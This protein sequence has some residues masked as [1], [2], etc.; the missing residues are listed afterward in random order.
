M[1]LNRL[2]T[3]G[4]ASFLLLYSHHHEQL[5]KY[6]C[7]NIL[8]TIKTSDT[9]LIKIY[10]SLYLKG[11]CVRGSWRPNRTA[12]Y[13]PPLLW[14]SPFFFPFS[15]AAQLKARGPS[16]LLG[17]VFSAASF[18]HLFWSPNW[19]NFLCTELYN[20][21]TSTQYLP[22]TSHRN[23]H[24]YRLWNGMF[25]RHR[26]EIT[27]MQ[28]TGHSLPV[29]QFVTVPWDSKPVPYCQPSPPTPMEYALPPSLEWHVWPGR[30]SV[31][32]TFACTDYKKYTD[33]TSLLLNL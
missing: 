2:E 28:F 25:D 20:S 21:S 1:V 3:T 23:M 7:R 19:L 12:T 31:Y 17:A 16:S 26:A 32:Y 11:L 18:L 4:L 8:N 10:L 27:V 14:P 30:R 24:F 13:W 6:T 33:C 15:W 9:V 29:H 22:I 5:Y